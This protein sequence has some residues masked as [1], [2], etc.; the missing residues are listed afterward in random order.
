MGKSLIGYDKDGKWNWKNCLRNIGMTALAVGATFI[1]VV[2]PVIGYGLLAAGVASG[3]TG[4]IKGASKL[5]DAKTEVEKEQARQ[6]ICSGVF[7]GVTSAFGLKGLGK[8]FARTQSVTSSPTTILGR[9]KQG[10]NDTFVN[11]FK[12]TRSAV[13]T[14]INTIRQGTGFWKLYGNK[15]TTTWKNIN[16]NQQKYNNKYNEMETEL[17]A[18]INNLETQINL[19]TDNAQKTLLQQQ[20]AMFEANLKEL[21]G[22][23]NIKTKVEYDN[24]RA[25]NSSSENLKTLS[26]YDSQAQVGYSL[27]ELNYAQS[28]Y[29]KDLN[30]LIDYKN[31]LMHKKARKPDLYKSE[32][33]EYTQTHIR[34]KYNT[35]KKLKEGKKSLTDR[36]TD[37]D[38][39]IANINN[40]LRTATGRNAKNL[41]NQ[42]RGLEKSK[43]DLKNELDVCNSIKLKSWRKWTTWNK[44]E[45]KLALGPKGYESNTMGALKFLATSAETRA[46]FA[47]SQWDREFSTP[48][49]LDFATLTPEQIKESLEQLELQK[50]EIEKTL[51]GLDEIQDYQTWE[52]LKAQ[53][54]AQAEALAQAEAQSQVQNT[55][56]ANQ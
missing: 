9:F 1:P 14:D 44:N 46:P 36:I 40:Q 10:F 11:S 29:N 30:K 8:S 24:L 20:K 48:C 15:L 50:Q 26:S 28:K 16:S 7:T 19:A 52:A 53:Q 2:G 41:R 25:T 34:N 21:R 51:E 3:V 4:V 35:S 47:F 56:E 23:S 6:D 32:L 49:S 17:N 45:Y 33:D 43:A 5:S 42:L 31:L 13:K 27:K 22:F 54:K 38:K 18:R 12:A 55:T 37:L 39:D